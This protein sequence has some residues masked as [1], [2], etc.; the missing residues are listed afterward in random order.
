MNWKL[1]KFKG[2]IFWYDKDKDSLSHPS[3]IELCVQVL[4]AF[5]RKFVGVSGDVQK[6]KANAVLVTESIVCRI[7]ALKRNVKPAIGCDGVRIAFVGAKFH[8]GVGK[9]Q[10]LDSTTVFHYEASLKSS[11]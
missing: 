9:I 4:Q 5:E 2:G 7:V 11:G 6:Y 8:S 10:L 1:G 3:S